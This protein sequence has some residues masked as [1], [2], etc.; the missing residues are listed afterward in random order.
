M[1]GCGG[2]DSGVV[3]NVESASAQIIEHVTPVAF[4][5]REL[6]TVLLTF[7][8]VVIKLEQDVIKFAIF[9]LP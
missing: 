4:S 9:E 5:F 7:V 6:K 2:I 8:S 3:L 1:A